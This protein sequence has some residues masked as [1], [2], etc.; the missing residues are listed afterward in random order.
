MDISGQKCDA[1]HTEATLW[2]RIVHKISGAMTDLVQYLGPH[3]PVLDIIN[4]LELVYGT[5][6]SFDIL[7]QKFHKLKQGRREI[8][9]VYMTSLRGC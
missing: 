3:T 2:D 4:N 6:A 8:V 1:M 5:V 7:M 9:P